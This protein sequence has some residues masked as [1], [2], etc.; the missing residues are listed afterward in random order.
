MLPSG[1][2]KAA[3][4]QTP[5]S[6][7]SAM[8][9]TP[10]ASSSALAADT[11]DTRMAK[12]ARLGTNGRSSRSGSQKLSVTFGVS[13]SPSVT[14]LAGSPSA[15]LYQAVARAAS[16]VGIEMKSTCSTR[17]TR[18]VKQRAPRE[19]LVALHGTAAAGGNNGQDVTNGGV[20]GKGQFK[21]TGAITDQGTDVAYRTVT[22]SL[23]TGHP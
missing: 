7:V 20:A 9:S 1:S 21:A 12:P 23:D 14:L 15:S 18:E 4:W 22:G 19:E 17:T 11:S 10:F 13:N 3:K 8:N 6:H 16:R 2:R 5:E